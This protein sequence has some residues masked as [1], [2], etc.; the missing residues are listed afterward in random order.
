MVSVS[1]SLTKVPETE[2][3]MWIRVTRAELDIVRQERKLVAERLSELD[4]DVQALERSLC[5]FDPTAG[6]PVLDPAK[7]SVRAMCAEM[8]LANGG[9][10]RTNE[11]SHHMADAGLY[12]TARTANKSMSTVLSRAKDF[13]RMGKGTWRYIGPNQ[14]SFPP[15][16]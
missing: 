10:L 1:L 12:P 16:S 8:A 13:E 4:A 6:Q 5:R 11:A 3:E 7:K 14:V 2:R 15:L 9:I